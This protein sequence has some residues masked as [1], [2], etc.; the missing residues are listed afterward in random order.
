MKLIIYLLVLILLL[1]CSDSHE[2]AANTRP[3]I[4]FIMA[5][6]HAYQAISAYGSQLIKTPNIDR[7]ANEGIRFDRAFVTNS[8]C[9]PSRAVI[10]TGMFSHLNGVLDNVQ[11]FDST[12][13]TFPKLLRQSGYQ[14]AMVGKWHLKSEPTGFDYWKVLPGQGDYYHPK[15][16]T[17]DG[18]VQDSGYV[19]DLITDEALSWLSEHRD[20]SKPFLLM[21]NHKAPHRQWWPAPRHVGSLGEVEFEAPKTLLD[22]YSNRGSSAKEAEMRI[23]THMGLTLDNKLRPERI[24]SLGFESFSKFYGSAFKRNY[25]K[26]TEEERAVWDAY[27]EPINDQFTAN[28]PEGDD[29]TRWKH[30]RYMEDYLGSIQALDENIG[31]LLD[32]LDEM[33]LVENTLVVYTSDQGFYL[34][35]HGWFDKRFMYEESFR[36]PL[37]MRWPGTIVPHSVNTQ[38]VQNLDFG[39]TFL[40]MAGVPIPSDMQGKS[41]I[42]LMKGEEANWR[43]AIY[44]HYYEYPGVHAVKRH[45]GA[46]TDRYKLIHFYHDVDEWELYDLELDPQELNNVIID[47]EYQSI[48]AEMMNHLRQLQDQYGDSDELANEIL[49]S[50]LSRN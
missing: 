35:E 38:L 33:G 18:I 24:K 26:L 6:D 1:G 15:F 9:S 7:I 50:D 34:G 45:Y 44:Y 39:E 40:E 36:T 29:L 41:L 11:K 12:Q 22:D 10:L 5:D 14:T 2:Q 48:K 32:Y 4:I 46:R 43:S 3:N 25:A 31:R 17:V 13:Q 49:Q 47:P 37:L 16:K 20:T 28:P 42:P 23:S 8:I 27:Y 21:Y 19:T 30:Q